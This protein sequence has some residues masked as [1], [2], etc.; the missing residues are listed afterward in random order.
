M[1]VLESAIEPRDYDK[2][3]NTY[4]KEGEKDFENYIIPRLK[5]R[6]Y[7][8]FN[9]TN[10]EEYRHVSIDYVIDKLNRTELPDI[11]TVIN[12]DNYEKIEVKNTFTAPKTD[13]VAYELTT[14]TKLTN[15]NR[16]KYRKKRDKN[17][18]LL[19]YGYD[20]A[21]WCLKTKANLVYHTFA[22]KETHEIEKRAWIYM[23]KWHE[24]VKNPLNQLIT[25]VLDNEHVVDL[26]CPINKMV[27]QGVLKYIKHY[28]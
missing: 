3:L 7:S 9:V 24:F 5:K 1:A 11:E 28:S 26:L 14:S 2:Y 22:N 25:N 23:D 15:K 21:G 12:D 16:K 10:I 8:M 20:C 27:E 6:N 13:N 17:G 18:N 19:E 4:G